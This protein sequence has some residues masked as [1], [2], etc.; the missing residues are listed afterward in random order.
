LNLF[1][2]VENGPL[3]RIDADGHADHAEGSGTQT[4]VQVQSGGCS[5]AN[6][7]G[8]PCTSGAA[9]LQ[10]GSQN[11]PH[12]H[13]KPKPKPKPL[14]KGDPGRTVP[15]P[16]KKPNAL[17]YQ[18]DVYYYT[19]TP[20]GTAN[21]ERHK[22]TLD[23][24]FVGPPARAKICQPTCQPGDDYIPNG[25]FVDG[26]MVVQG[27]PFSV[28]RTWSVDGQPAQV[29]NDQNQPF[30]FEIQHNST[31]TNPPFQVEYGNNPPQ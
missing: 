8:E 12:H 31:Q 24:T 20:D 23:E 6:S 16:N 2:Y 3:N 1:S 26:Q 30:D 19:V 14:V 27:D 22:V 11:K 25:E 7:N 5:G 13:P 18:R 15:D 17:V 4:G 9:L 21:H 10:T 28:K 29:L